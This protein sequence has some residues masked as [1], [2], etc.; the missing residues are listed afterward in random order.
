MTGVRSCEGVR[1]DPWRGLSRGLEEKIVWLEAAKAPTSREAAL[2]G[3][4]L[5]IGT[6]VGVEGNLAR[7]DVRPHL[8]IIY[9]F[10]SHSK[11]VSY[12]PN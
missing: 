8:Q 7:H 12:I 9:R 11:L 3:R 4:F 10:S 2:A 6:L 5:S 1:Q